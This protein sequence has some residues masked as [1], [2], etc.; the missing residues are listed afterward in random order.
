[1]DFF[2]EEAIRLNEGFLNNIFKNKK[3]EKAKIE[4]YLETVHK[5]KQSLI[6]IF[7]TIIN[8]FKKHT[9]KYLGKFNCTTHFCSAEELYNEVENDIKNGYS[10]NLAFELFIGRVCTNYTEGSMTDDEDDKFWDAATDMI[11]NKISKNSLL[12]KYGRVENRSFRY[13]QGDDLDFC[14]YVNPEIIGLDRDKYGF[15]EDILN[16]IDHY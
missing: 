7:N 14:F 9:S 13:Y 8:E 6:T 5:N 3:E 4:K 15:L 10:I 1:M 16:G 2:E 11:E 12:L